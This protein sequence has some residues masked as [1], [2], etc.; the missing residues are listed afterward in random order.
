MNLELVSNSVLRKKTETIKIKLCTSHSR[1]LRNRNSRWLRGRR[2]KVVVFVLQV[3]QCIARVIGVRED[4]KNAPWNIGEEGTAE[5]TQ[6]IG[7]QW[8]VLCCPLCEVAHVRNS[9]TMAME[10]QCTVFRIIKRNVNEKIAWW[11]ALGYI[12]ST[13]QRPVT[14]VASGAD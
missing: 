4:T 14:S 12:I 2:H 6:R 7:H 1:W 3:S 5:C 8:N 10:L 11:I 13:T 9:Q